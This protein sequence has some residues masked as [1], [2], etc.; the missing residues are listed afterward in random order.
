MTGMRL[1]LQGNNSEPY[2]ITVGS[3]GNVWFAQCNSASAYAAVVKVTP[4][5]QMT[6]FPLPAGQARC[7]RWVALGSDGAIWF[8]EFSPQSGNAIAL[9]GRI[10]VQGS[11]SEF[12]LPAN[13]EP[14]GIVNGTDGNLWYV[15]SSSGS[16]VVR[17]F[18]PATD[19]IVGSITNSAF[20]NA[21]GGNP[22]TVDSSNGDLIVAG[23]S[24]ALPLLVVP[25]ANPSLGPSLPNSLNGCLYP[26]A[27]SASSIYFK[28]GSAA[29][30]E[31]ASVS[32]ASYSVSVFNASPSGGITSIAGPF[33]G[34]AGVIYAWG[35]Y[36]PSEEMIASGGPAILSITPSGSITAYYQD[37]SGPDSDTAEQA[38]YGQDGNLWVTASNP[39]APGAVLRVQP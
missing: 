24:A 8:T 35:S 19:A 20:L 4:A 16:G 7:P 33:V 11:V 32:S 30:N 1:S 2:G 15:A 5:G 14:M 10:N 27:T 39:V 37:G 34:A 22:I 9:V 31:L 6:L 38:V 18:S 12:T 25:G 17:G 36:A 21:S 13:D 3:D 23:A 26:S 29:S 28:C